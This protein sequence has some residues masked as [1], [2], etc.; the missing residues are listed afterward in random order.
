MKT[1]AKT[2]SRDFGLSMVLY[3]GAILGTNFYLEGQ[4]DSVPQLVAAL[5]ALLPM[6]PI[7]MAARAVLVFSRSWDELQRKQALEAMLI[8]FFIVGMGSFSYGFLEGV[9][10]P[11]LEVIWIF[12]ALIMTQGLAQVFVRSRY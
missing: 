6:L 9:G 4:E 3:V 5:I 8:A 10:F 2:Y 1:A 7:V 11:K 12:P